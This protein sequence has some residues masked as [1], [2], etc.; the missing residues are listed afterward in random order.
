MYCS[1]QQGGSSQVRFEPANG[2][3][4]AAASDEVVSI[5]DVETDMQTHLFQV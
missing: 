1:C 5:F 4:L 3:L 2:R